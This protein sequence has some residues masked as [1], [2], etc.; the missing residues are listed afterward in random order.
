MVS[1]TIITTATKPLPYTNKTRTTSTIF[2]TLTATCITTIPTDTMVSSTIISQQP[3]H[4]H[5]PTKLGPLPP[6][7]SPSQRPVSPLYPQIPWFQAPSLP[8]QPKPLPCTNK[9]RTAST[10]F[11]TLTAT[12][13]TTIPTDTMVSSTIITTATKTATIHQQ[14]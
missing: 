4:Y 1:S 10:I 11:I 6:S 5:T 7:S 12:C 13:I 14:N 3:N 2:I 8:Q 9:T